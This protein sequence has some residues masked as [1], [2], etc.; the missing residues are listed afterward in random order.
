MNLLDLLDFLFYGAYP[1]WKEF[2]LSLTN[3]DLKALRLV[4]KT[5]SADLFP[6]LFSRIYISAHSSDL[7]VFQRIATH[8]TAPQH[9][10]ELVW[11]DCTFDRWIGGQQ[12]YTDRLLATST[13][14]RHVLKREH[15]I[16]ADAYRFWASEAA[17]FAENREEGV[18]KQIFNEHVA[19]FPQLRSIVVLSRSRLTYV[20]PDE[21]WALWQT[22]RS[23][24]WNAKSFARYLLPPEPFKPSTGTTVIQSEGI[25]PMQIIRA[26]ARNDSDFKVGHLSINSIGSGQN[27]H[28]GSTMVNANRFERRF[29]I[30]LQ[31][32][33]SRCP[34][35]SHGKVAL[36]LF[37]E[38]QTEDI[39]RNAGV[40]EDNL[41]L[42]MM[43]TA[44]SLEG[45]T[46]SNVCLDWMLD[47]STLV[48]T[49]FPYLRTLKRVTIEGGSS[50]NPLQLLHFLAYQTSVREVVFDQLHLEAVTWSEVLLALKQDKI[51][52][53]CFELKPSRAKAQ[54]FPQPVESSWTPE[55]T[56]LSGM[57][58]AW[59]KGETEEFP[60]LYT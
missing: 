22:P 33:T 58:V 9:V 1:I 5:T 47:Y 43:D 31:Q 56:A 57:I 46:V 30:D 40:L 27:R 23:R 6:F 16:I 35:T 36:Q 39:F 52:F 50:D 55:R 29:H 45:L 11:D 21:Y 42:M 3:Q 37:L 49:Q 38:T 4:H 8:P 2:I 44:S 26:K 53:D 48:N 10:R 59:L 7:D 34:D 13:L 41:D 15:G 25:R 51:T 32:L 24:I 19:C 20:D 17:S 12:T 14:P 18:D 28:S 54:L 60:L